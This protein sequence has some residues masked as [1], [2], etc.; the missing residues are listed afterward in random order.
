V[1][2]LSIVYAAILGQK[3]AKEKHRI[4]ELEIENLELEKRNREHPTF[5]RMSASHKEGY[6][7]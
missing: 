6:L 2:I 1:A 5:F 3:E 4:M 7:I